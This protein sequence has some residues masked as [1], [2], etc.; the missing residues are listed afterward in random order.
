M[1]SSLNN[2][3]CIHEHESTCTHTC[4]KSQGQPP[5]VD[6]DPMGIYQLILNGK[7]NFPRY[8]GSI[9]ACVP[10]GR[11]IY[12]YG[13]K[14]QQE[15]RVHMNYVPLLRY[16][17]HNAKSLLKKILVADLTKRFGT[18]DAPQDR[19]GCELS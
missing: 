17:E 6:D 1:H 5:F 18:C 11:R 15:L 7:V 16:I 4:Q 13:R 9:C 10:T 8:F 19:C 3:T 12:A 2:K 14:L